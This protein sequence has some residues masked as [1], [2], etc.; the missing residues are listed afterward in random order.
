MGAFALDGPPD[1]PKQYAIAPMALAPPKLPKRGPLG[2][3]PKSDQFSIEIDHILTRKYHR[4]FCD[5]LRG[6]TNGF[7]NQFS[8][9]LSF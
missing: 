4:I 3:W 7:G 5:F 2:N 8:W 1:P 9:E 6:T